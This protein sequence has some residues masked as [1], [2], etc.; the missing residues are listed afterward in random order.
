MSD[1]DGRNSDGASGAKEDYDANVLHFAER[2]G[3]GP[4]EAF[5]VLSISREGSDPAEGGRTAPERA[6]W[7]MLCDAASLPPERT[8]FANDDDGV[9]TKAITEEDRQRNEEA[10]SNERETLEA[11]FE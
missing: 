2:Y 5:A 1:D 3:L 8:C 9:I 4:R 6:F 11:I 10:A 7:K